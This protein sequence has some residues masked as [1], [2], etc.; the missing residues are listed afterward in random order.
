[1]SVVESSTTGSCGQPLI[2]PLL[3]GGGVGASPNELANIDRPPAVDPPI[4]IPA[5]SF[6]SDEIGSSLPVELVPNESSLRVSSEI[7][8]L[9]FGWFM[10]LTE[11]P[12]HFQ[13]TGK[14]FNSNNFN[15]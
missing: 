6:K 14:T 15:N 3:A 12:H 7:K 4:C 11:I 5:A 1:M 8:R 2:I 10:R 9:L 13:L